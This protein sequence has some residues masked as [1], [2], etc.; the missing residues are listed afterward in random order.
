VTKE[1]KLRRVLRIRLEQGFF[2][3]E[4]ERLSFVEE[5]MAYLLGDWNR[6]PFKVLKSHRH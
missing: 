6:V 2:I 3:P 4:E 5:M 1:E